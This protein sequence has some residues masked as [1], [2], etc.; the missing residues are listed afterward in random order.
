MKISVVMSCYNSEQ[1]IAASINSILNQTFTDFEFIIWNDGSSDKTEEIVKSFN[2]PRIRYFYHENTGLGMALQLA[3]K[4]AKGEYIARMDADDIAEPERFEKELMILDSNPNVVLVSSA[5]NYIDDDN[6]RIGISYPYVSSASIKKIMKKTGVSIIVH[7][8]A[9][10]RKDAYFNAGG[11]LALK[12]AQ[13][14]LL[15]SRMMKFGDFV[16][17]KEPL[18]N[19]RITGGSISS[20]TDGNAYGALITAYRKKMIDD[21]EV[22]GHDIELYNQLVSLS[23]KVNAKNISV[24]NDNRK[25]KPTYEKVAMFL[26]LFVGKAKARNIII[27]VKDFFARY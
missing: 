11:Y 15:F 18:L 27:M 16:N 24:A 3:C 20:Q 22:M 17:I 26:S 12:K 2:D 7:P 13:D 14:H 19:Y 8:A 6:K 25:A 23:K 9:M 1:F 5:V 10:F 21:E 4:E